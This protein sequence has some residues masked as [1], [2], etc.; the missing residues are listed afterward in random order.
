MVRHHQR[1]DCRGG[2]GG[3]GAD[4][5]VADGTLVLLLLLLIRI[6]IPDPPPEVS[7][8]KNGA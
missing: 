6:G 3:T 4:E 2:K 5:N 8:T 7:P 1:S